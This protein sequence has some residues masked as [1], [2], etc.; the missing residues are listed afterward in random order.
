MSTQT[1]SEATGVGA[2]EDPGAHALRS[3][4][5]SAAAPPSARLDARGPA[6]YLHP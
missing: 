2:S 1:N 5:E 3:A 6:N 4:G